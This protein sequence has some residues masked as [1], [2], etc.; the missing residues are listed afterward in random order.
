MSGNPP[1]QDRTAASPAVPPAA[2]HPAAQAGGAGQEP[3]VTSGPLVG[4]DST[5]RKVVNSVLAVVCVVGALFVIYQLRQPIAWLVIAA[6][7]AIAVSGPVAVLAR[8]MKRGLA[9][10]IVYIALILIPCILLALLLPPFINQ[11][12]ALVNAFPDYVD[13]VSRFVESNDT[14]SSIN[15]EFDVT[16]SLKREV[17]HLDVR[18]NLGDAAAVLGDIGVKLINSIFAFVMILILSIF[19]V[20]GAARWRKAFM[21]YQPSH[22]APYID[23]ALDRIALAVGHYVGGALIQATVAGTTAFIMLTILGAPFAAPLALIVALFDLIPVV[24]ATIAAVLVGVVMLFVNFPVGLVI[25]ILFA[26]AYQQFENYVIQ[27]QIQKRATSIEAF[28]IL[29]AVL[30]GSTLFGVPGALLA[31]PTAATIQISLREYFSYRRKMMELAAGAQGVQMQFPTT[32]RQE[33]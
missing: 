31:I 22:R 7:I 11:I 19:M 16:G 24:G 32:S 13:D 9:I 25:W 1:D 12:S 33:V 29:I 10:A 27:P 4:F 26:I 5:I 8:Y 2:A 6:F 18:E 20:G 21:K 17:Q 14:L 3:I 30:F 15:K 23:R 28:V